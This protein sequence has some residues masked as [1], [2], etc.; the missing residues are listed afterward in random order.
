[1]AGLASTTVDSPFG[2]LTL[3]ADA[4]GLAAILWPE[5]KG[6][7]ALGPLMPQPGHPV[8]RQAAAQL[9]EYFAGTRTA[10]TVP[11]SF[12][13]TP[14]QR[15]VWQ[16]LLTI[17]YGETRTYAEIARQVGS[18]DASRAVGAAN[19]KNPIS[20]IAPCHRVVGTGGKLTGFAGGMAAKAH[21]LNLEQGT[22]T[23]F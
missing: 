21:L 14:F 23:L 16:A 9:A 19:G 3:V 17:P 6:R 11:L 8:L 7:V 1:M 10:F 4:H 18:P 20:I 22:P 5:D 13:G 2:Q 15:K 12:H